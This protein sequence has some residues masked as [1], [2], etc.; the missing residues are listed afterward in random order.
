MSKQKIVVT[1]ATGQLGRLV[2]KHLLNQVEASNIIAAVRT[3]DNAKDIAELGVE[4]READYSKPVTLKSAFE[5]ADKVLLISS[6]EI[7]QRAEQHKNVIEAAKNAGVSLI[8]YTSLLHA[9][10]SPLA[11]AEEH[12]V[13]ESDLAESGVPYVLLRNGWYTENYLSSVGPS[14]EHGAFAGSAGNGK[15]SSAGRENYAEAAVAVLLSQD[16]QAGKVYEL[17]GDESYTLT[18]LA[19][20]ISRESGKEIPYM[21]LPESE[22]KDALIGAGLPEGLAGLLADSD[23]GASKGGLFNDARQLSQLIGRPTEDVESLLKAFL[24]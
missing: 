11:L 22:Y 18:E 15:V 3:P 12:I 21:D 7:G 19:A 24:A 9:D 8:A 20:L 5:G 2:L 4:V 6:S 13:T 17:A 23:V 1:G 10:S 14:I 16:S